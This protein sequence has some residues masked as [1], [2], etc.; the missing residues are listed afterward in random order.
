[1]CLYVSLDRP[2]FLPSSILELQTI[3]LEVDLL[4]ILS[5]F[6]WM[7]NRRR[8]FF[9]AYTI[10]TFWHFIVNFLSAHSQIEAQFSITNLES[11]KVFASIEI[12]STFNIQNNINAATFTV[13]TRIHKELRKNRKKVLWFCFVLFCVGSSWRRKVNSNYSGLYVDCTPPNEEKGVSHAISSEI[14]EN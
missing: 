6:F 11:R 10:P 2:H 1:M 5:F 13:H 3:K 8:V 7:E 14:N 4:I 9:M 12:I